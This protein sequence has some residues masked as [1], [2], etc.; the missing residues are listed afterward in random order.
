MTI[1]IPS[2]IPPL[3]AFFGAGLGAAFYTLLKTQPYLANRSFDPK[4]N[5]AYVSRFITGLISGVILATTLH[6]HFG[7]ENQGAIAAFSP[8]VLAILGGYSSEAVENILQRLVEVLLALVRGDGAAQ[9]Q[10]E[11]TAQQAQNNADVRGKLVDLEKA[12]ANND[13]KGFDAVLTD[14]HTTLK[15]SEG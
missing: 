5:G 6:L 2:F 12:Q 11:A 3:N 9:S 4:Y 13:Q 7:S 14:I 10:A 1:E 15:K 8:G